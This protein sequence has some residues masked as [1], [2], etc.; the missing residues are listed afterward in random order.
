MLKVNLYPITMLSKYGVLK[1]KKE[2]GKCGLVSVSSYSA[3]RPYTRAGLYGGCKRYDATFGKLIKRKNVD[4]IVLYPGLVTTSMVGNI[5]NWYNTCL[6][7]ET[8][9]GTL[10]NLGLAKY[11]NGSLIHT[12]WA[13]Q[14][15]W[16]PEFVRNIQRRA[17]GAAVPEGSYDYWFHI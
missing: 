5:S 10:S 9:S 4:S 13:I 11:T 3:L 2:E 15:S 12:L 16:T 17:E 7:E 6:P 14:I 8:A 1:F